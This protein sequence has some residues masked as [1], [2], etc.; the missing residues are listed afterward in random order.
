MSSSESRPS[1]FWTAVAAVYAVLILFPMLWMA[2][3]MVKPTDAMF[4][5]PTVLLFQPTLQHFGSTGAC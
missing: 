4:A 5:R 1:L 2:T 3:M